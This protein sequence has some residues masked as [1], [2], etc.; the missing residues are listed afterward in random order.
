VAEVAGV[1]ILELEPKPLRSIWSAFLKVAVELPFGRK[2][3]L[4]PFTRHIACPIEHVTAYVL[5]LNDLCE[6]RV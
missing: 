5:L 3:L 1:V 6:V 2:S 4:T